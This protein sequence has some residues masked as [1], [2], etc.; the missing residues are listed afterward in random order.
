MAT[1][2]V[3]AH[4]VCAIGVQ[5]GAGI[6]QFGAWRRLGGGWM[7]SR[8]FWTQ[9]GATL[10]KAFTGGRFW[11]LL[12]LLYLGLVLAITLP[13]V[14]YALA[15]Y[16]YQVDAA[17]L[18]EQHDL[19]GAQLLARAADWNS[20]MHAWTALVAEGAKAHDGEAP[21]RDAAP[22]DGSTG[23]GSD[24]ETADPEVPAS[25]TGASDAADEAA[26][27]AKAT[28]AREA[29]VLQAYRDAVAGLE[30]PAQAEQS[31]QVARALASELQ[32]FDRL[33]LPSW[34]LW[35]VRP[36]AFAVLP[37]WT[38]TLLVTRAAGLV[39]SLIFVR[40]A[41]LRQRLD[42]WSTGTKAPCQPRPWSWLVLRPVFGVVIAFGA[43]VALQSG[44]LAID[45]AMALSPSAYVTAAVGLIAGLLSWQVIET[46]ENAGER[47]LASQRP[48]WAYGLDGQ[49]Q[50]KSKTAEGLATTVGV[51]DAVMQDWIAL[52][53]PVPKDTAKRI[54]AELN[55]CLEQLFQ[56]VPP[57]RRSAET[58]KTTPT[59]REGQE[60][61]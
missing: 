27:E 37:G 28:A 59:K 31:D 38:L 30:T 15:A 53:V 8:G 24:R 57:W 10:A 22:G 21:D 60:P 43:Y 41:T 44:L 26:A 14:F 55:V 1:R 58:A 2:I 39:G 49:M 16:Q 7:S 11:V 35:S 19:D 18:A 9:A 40:K 6:G 4:P 50:A 61:A 47:W 48:L 52:R 5:L 32:R 51:S 46:I 17:A 54:A 36:S 25:E 3:S 56:P 34:I 12:R 13:M 29:R 23:D 42:N 33:A 20:A 45:G